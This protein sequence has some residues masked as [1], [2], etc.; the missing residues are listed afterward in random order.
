MATLCT[1][2]GGGLADADAFCGWCGTARASPPRRRTPIFVASIAA[3]A[4]VAGLGA[5]VLASDDPPCSERIEPG[6]ELRNCEL[7]ELDLTAFDLRGTDLQDADLTSASL[8]GMDLRTTKLA[9]ARLTG[10]NLQ[11][12][13]LSSADLRGAEL[14][15]ADLEGADLREAQLE[16]AVLAGANLATA[17]LTAAS[18]AG[19]D[20]GD[21]T[22][23]FAQLQGADLTGADLGAAAIDNVSFL[24]AKG[25]TDELLAAALSV[26]LG[27]LNQ[28]LN[29]SSVTLEDFAALR[30]ALAPAC[31][32]I[33][34][35]GAATVR[36]TGAP[37]FIVVGDV[38]SAATSAGPA[39][40]R[41]A[42]FVACVGAEVDEVVEQCGPYVRED[43]LF[44]GDIPRHERH[45]VVDVVDPT[46]GAVVHTERVQGPPSDCPFQTRQTD[47]IRDQ[48]LS[49]P[50][51]I[52]RV[53]DMVAALLRPSG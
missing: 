42:E 48:P 10:A 43:G 28:A 44:I 46:T 36:A 20:L 31:D 9:G 37:A 52:E 35:P 30:T 25:V 32:G 2:C 19:A 7:R 29:A 16:G 24:G 12:A 51:V 45:R 47:A 27:E 5:F 49:A 41:F 34:V 26:E 6:A 40:L 13:D 8:T 53:N 18:L 14:S 17:D 15:N 11:G 22:L 38:A 33:V 3:L 21:A 4:L 50:E 23:S 1:R 39:A